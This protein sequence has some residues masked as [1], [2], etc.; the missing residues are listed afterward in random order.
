MSKTP[1]E[2]AHGLKEV[3]VEHRATTENHRQLAEPIVEPL[4]ESGRVKL[5]LEPNSPLLTI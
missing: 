4:I 5:G 3:I 2:A 1:L